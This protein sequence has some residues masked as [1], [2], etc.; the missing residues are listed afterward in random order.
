[1]SLSISSGYPIQMFFQAIFQRTSQNFFIL[2]I[3]KNELSILV[4]RKKGIGYAFR[5]CACVIT[6]DMRR[7]RSLIHVV[8]PPQYAVNMLY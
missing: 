2:A 5:N 3:R 6:V 7:V 8:L 4:E 1:M